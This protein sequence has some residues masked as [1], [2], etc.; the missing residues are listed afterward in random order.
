M[1]GIKKT[2]KKNSPMHAIS[3][4]MDWLLIIC[5]LTLM[6]IG[7]IMVFSAS[8]VMAE[9]E[10][11]DAYLFIRRHS[12]FV[13]MGLG[14][15]A[16]TAF[17]RREFFYN[18]T[19]PM[20]FLVIVLLVLVLVSPLGHSAGGA[21]RWLRFLGFSLQPME[22]TKV[23]LIFYLAYFFSHKQDKVRTFSVGFLPPVFVTGIL[24][25]LLLLQPDFGGA[26]VLCMLLFLMSLAGGTS[27]VYLGL[28]AVMGLGSAALLII[29]SSYRMKRWTAFLDPFS[30]AQNT[31]Y[32][33]VQSLYAFG[34]GGLTGEGLGAGRQKLLFLPEAHNDFILAVLGEELGFLGV[35]CVFICFGILLW[36]AFAI[37]L[38]QKKHHDQFIAY[39]MALILAIGA[40]LNAAVVLGMAPPKGVA[41]P[42]ISYGGTSLL[43]SSFCVGML[44]NLSRSKVK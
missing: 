20:L 21:K 3:W 15:M 29:Q 35:S 16:C 23:V 42:F 12:L 26:A 33:L 24:C 5:A 8:G 28:S 9:R 22:V 27:P 41:M 39:G 37:A 13:L 2:T 7:L 38:N 44:L 10:F 31:G 14:V 34:S 17:G 19:Y 18:L 25:V 36:R 6:A 32:Q 30:D 11:G 40:I 43:V 4:R 1:T